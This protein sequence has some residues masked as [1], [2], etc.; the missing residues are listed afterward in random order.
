MVDKSKRWLEKLIDAEA[1]YGCLAGDPISDEER[2]Q[3][4]RD[5]AEAQ[6]RYDIEAR[7]LRRLEKRRELRR[8]NMLIKKGKTVVGQLKP[9]GEIISTRKRLIAVWERINNKPE[10]IFIHWETPYEHCC[11]IKTV[12]FGD[13]EFYAV[14]RWA[15]R[16]R[17]YTLVKQ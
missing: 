1:K 16:V 7:R 17:G 15:L 12:K 8:G 10:K 11:N 14:T 3:V 2:A 4:D 6:K 5:L 9:T 13:K